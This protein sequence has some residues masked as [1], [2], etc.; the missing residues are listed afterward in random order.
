MEVVQAM[1]MEQYKAV[2][3]EPHLWRIPVIS[4]QCFFCSFQELSRFPGSYV[5]LN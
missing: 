3:E 2:E 1:V 5:F 4:S